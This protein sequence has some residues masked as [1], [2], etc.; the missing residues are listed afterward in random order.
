MVRPLRLGSRFY[1]IFAKTLNVLN[2]MNQLDVK[3]GYYLFNSKKKIIN[4]KTNLKCYSRRRRWPKPWIISPL[5]TGRRMLRVRLCHKSISLV[6]Y[7]SQNLNP[8]TFSRPP[9]YLEVGHPSPR[10]HHGR[11]QDHHSA[12]TQAGQHPGF[13]IM[14]EGR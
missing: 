4:L 13:I 9:L 2:L 12:S 11:V 10:D 3:L 6:D 1:I 7:Q 5:K 8:F 14:C